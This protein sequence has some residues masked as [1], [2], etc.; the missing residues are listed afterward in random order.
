MRI[1]LLGAGSAYGTPMIFNR[2]RGA[3]PNNPKN[4]RSRA[5]VLIEA[6]CKSILI[7]AGPDVRYQ[8]NRCN[9]SDVDAVL[10]THGHYDHIGGVPELPRASKL[11]A[12]VIDVWASAE[13]TDE[14]KNCYGYLFKGEEPEG[15]GVCW[16]MLPDLGEFNCC[17]LAFKTFQVPHH[18]WHSS[19]FRYKDFA[20]VTD[21]E[22]MPEE[23]KEVLKGVKLLFV[24]CNNGVEPEKNGHSDLGCAENL[25]SELGI[26]QVVLTHLSARVD[27]D[28]LA[29]RLPSEK[30]QVGYDGLVAELPD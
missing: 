4:I 14:L 23:G 15:D 19:A 25:A 20:Y 28:V 6:E 18:R 21:W 30:W 10:L 5:S 7:D 1:T 27:Y 22:G 3:N 17:G 26:E 24:E 9:V 16:K 2:W 13:T 12:H 29:A 8:I 11:A